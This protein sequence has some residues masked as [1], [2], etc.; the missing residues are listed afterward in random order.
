[1]FESLCSLSAHIANSMFGRFQY[2]V[3]NIIYWITLFPD[4]NT[5]KIYGNY[6]QV[7]YTLVEINKISCQL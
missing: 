7:L 1:M 6:W 2:N 4:L 3:V 5:Q